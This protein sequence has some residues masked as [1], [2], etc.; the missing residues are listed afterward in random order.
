M[1]IGIIGYGFVGKALAQAFVDSVEIYK[2]DPKLDTNIN[3]LIEF[4]PD[5]IFVCLPTPMSDDGTQNISIVKNTLLEIKKI[6]L[7]GILVLK[8]TVHPGNIEELQSIHPNIVYNP[9]FLREKHA[10]DDL[11]NSNLIVFGGDSDSSSYISEVYC[12]YTKCTNKDHIFT[13][14]MTASLLKYT[15][16]SFLATKVI[17]FNEFKN[18]FDAIDANDS[19]ENFI[20][21][22]S[23][24]KRIGSSHMMVPGHDGR[25][26]FGG[27]CLPKDANALIKYSQNIKIDLNLLENVIKTNN[28]IRASYDDET[29][30]EHEQN[31]N[32]NSRKEEL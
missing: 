9:E 16:N 26:G 14:V 19:W 2:V 11:I 17:F 7:K 31:I 27:A 28:K 22:I 3:N 1:R 30:R 13:D 18:L 15:I 12:N 5:V 6:G 10:I 20:R 23:R 8:S 29:H 21:Y 32:Y 24:D 25:H 4:E